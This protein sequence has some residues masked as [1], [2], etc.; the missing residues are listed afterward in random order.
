MRIHVANLLALQQRAQAE[1]VG[2]VEA[3]H[4]DR[5]EAVQVAGKVPEA[6]LSVEAAVN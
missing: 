4:K 5:I 2:V 3:C 6:R 1:D